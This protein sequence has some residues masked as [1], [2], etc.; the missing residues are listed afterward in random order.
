MLD[1]GDL[2]SAFQK[3]IRSGSWFD[4]DSMKKALFRAAKGYLKY[5]NEI[6]HMQVLKPLLRIIKKLTSSVKRKI[7]QKGLE[8]AYDRRK[9]FEENDVFE[10]C[11][12]A[13]EW[14]QDM[15]Y[16]FFLGVQSMDSR[17]GFSGF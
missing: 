14:L 2:K 15:D 11:P 8:E 13:R 16:I 12:Q 4:L 6:V 1:Y 9:K 10:W 17:G 5:G 7:W 3:G